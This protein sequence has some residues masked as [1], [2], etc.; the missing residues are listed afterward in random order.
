MV[1]KHGAREATRLPKT[2]TRGRIQ[3]G[4]LKE[5]VGQRFRDWTEETEIRSVLGWMTA[6]ATSRSDCFVAA[7]TRDDIT[8][9][10]TKNKFPQLS[11]RRPVRRKMPMTRYALLEKGRFER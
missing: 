7:K 3:N 9:V 2:G 10:T 11:L 1:E 6:G 5:R 4:V 8:N